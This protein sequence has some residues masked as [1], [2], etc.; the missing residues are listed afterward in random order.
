[1]LELQFKS[2]SGAGCASSRCCRQCTSSS[3]AAAAALST[4]V[5]GQ[6]AQKC[7]ANGM[8]PKTPELQGKA[9]NG[10]CSCLKMR[11]HNAMHDKGRQRSLGTPT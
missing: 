6:H 9:A 2:L 5:V 4:G 3:T 1:M 7:L 10:K 8:H 11:M